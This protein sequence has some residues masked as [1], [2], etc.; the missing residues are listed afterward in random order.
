MNEYLCKRING[1]Y[2]QA[3]ADSCEQSI[4]A[5]NTLVS[6]FHDLSIDTANEK[7]LEEIGKLIGFIRPYVPD[8]FIL[9]NAFL[10][11]DIPGGGGRVVSYY[12]G[13][14]SLSHP[15]IGGRFTSIDTNLVKLPLDIYRDL[16]KK[17]SYIKYNGLTI[18]SL[19]NLLSLS[20]AGYL[21]TWDVN[22]DI[23]VSFD[24]SYLSG[25]FVYVLRQIIDIFAVQPNILITIL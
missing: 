6:Y 24:P 13:F 16:L 3:I 22:H 4:T 11:F 18:V 9:D 1:I 5:T 23:V 12:N 8:A 25:L 14:S 15:E 19:D 17:V 21:I 20:T 7:E 2:G 10:F